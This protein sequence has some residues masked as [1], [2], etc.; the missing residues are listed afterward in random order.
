MDAYGDGKVTA[1]ARLVSTP[2]SYAVEEVLDGKMEPGVHAA[3]A[4]PA[5]AA[6]WLA[7][8]ADAGEVMELVDNLSK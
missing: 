8:L 6:A 7:K 4:E 5:K 3:P 2:V 1:M